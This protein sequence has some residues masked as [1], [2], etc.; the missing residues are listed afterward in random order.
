MEIKNQIHL[1]FRIISGGYLVR[2]QLPLITC[3]LLLGLSP[4]Y[5]IG[6]DHFYS[7]EQNVTRD[8]PVE[9]KDQINHFH[10]KY[11]TKGELVNL[12]LSL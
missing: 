9:V 4:I 3:S 8:K 5:L 1:I 2:A 6:C 10:K 12:H 7:G 11:R